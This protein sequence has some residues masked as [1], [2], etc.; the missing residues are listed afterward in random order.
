MNLYQ[1]ASQEEAW[2]A[3]APNDDLSPWTA[4]PADPPA[5]MP[6]G[7]VPLDAALDAAAREYGV[8]AD[9][10]RALGPG[11]SVDSIFDTAASLR[12]RLEAFGGDYAQAL[13]SYRQAEGG[14]GGNIA[15]APPAAALSPPPL[16]DAQMPAPGPAPAREHSARPAGAAPRPRPPRAQA[17]TPA[18]GAPPLQAARQGPKAAPQ[19]DGSSPAAPDG[20]LGAAD[21]PRS[22]LYR[23][24]PAPQTAFMDEVK[25]QLASGAKTLARMLPGTGA[26]AHW[27]ASQSEPAAGQ[28]APPSA[29]S[30]FERTALPAPDLPSRDLPLRP[31]TRKAANNAWDAASPQDRQRMQALPGWQGQ[32]ARERAAQFAQADKG[33][34]AESPTAALFDTRVEGRTRALIAK[35]E[36][37]DFARRAAR[38]GAAAGVAP[39]QEVKALGSTV[40][41]APRH[42]AK[43]PVP[44]MTPLSV[45]QD[46]LSGALQIGTTAAKGGADIVRMATGDAVG[47]DFSDSMAARAQIIKDMVGSDRAKAQEHNFQVDWADPNVSA[48]EMLARNKGAVSDKLLPSAG[49]MLLPAGVATGAGKAATLGRTALALDRTALAAR[50]A[51]AQTAAGI[52]ATAAQNAADVF[53]GLLDKGHSPEE[54]YTAAG[55]SVP[56]SIIAGKLTGGGA[57]TALARQAMRQGTDKAAK[58][59]LA[60]G[61]AGALKAG[62]RDGTQEVIEDSGQ[63]IGEAIATD[64]APTAN[65]AAKRGLLAFTMG[66]AMGGGTHAAG[67]T[68]TPRVQNQPTPP[69]VPSQQDAAANKTGPTTE[70]T[71]PAA[72]FARSAGTG[73]GTGNAA[74]A[75][76]QASAPDMAAGPTGEPAP[77]ATTWSDVAAAAKRARAEAEILRQAAALPEQNAAASTPDT[78]SRNTPSATPAM[79]TTATAAATNTDIGIGSTSH[80]W[81]RVDTPPQEQASSDADQA[82][83]STQ[84]TAPD[85]APATTQHGTARHTAAS[86]VQP[87]TTAPIDAQVQALDSGMLVVGGDQATILA[88]LQAGGIRGAEPFAGVTLVPVDQAALAQQVLSRPLAAPAGKRADR[89]SQ[90]ASATATLTWSGTEAQLAPAAT[91]APTAGGSTADP[92]AVGASA[93]RT[94][95]RHGSPTG[96]AASQPVPVMEMQRDGTLMV[97]GDSVQLEERLRAGGVDRVLRREGGVLVGLDQV[98]KARQLFSNPQ[99]TQDRSRAAPPTSAVARREVATSQSDFVAENHSNGYSDNDGRVQEPTQPDDGRGSTTGRS[100]ATA[101]DSVRGP[102]NAVPPRTASLVGV[103]IA[104]RIERAGSQSLLGEQVDSP[105]RLAELAQVYRDPRFETFR[106]F[107]IK[108]GQVVHATGVSARLPGET[109]MVPAGMTFSEYI[110]EFRDNMQRTGADGYY[111]LHNHPSGNPRPSPEDLN[112]TADLEAHVP[113]M[114]A[115]VV[116]N[117]NK[118]AVIEPTSAG[119]SPD[120]MVRFRY[121]GEDRLLKASKPMAVLGERI[122]GSDDL[123]IVGKSMQRPGWITLIGT[124][125][126]GKVRAIS[127]APA[128]ILTRNYP[129]L[130]ATVRRFMRQSGSGSVFAVGDAGDIGSKPVRDALA[131]GIL[132]DALP[133]AGRTL[134]QQGVHTGGTGFSLTRGRR[135]AEGGPAPTSSSAADMET[136]RDGTLMVRG[137]SVQL[138]ERLRQGGVERVLRREGGVLVGLDQVRKARQLLQQQP[139]RAPASADYSLPSPLSEQQFSRNAPDQNLSRARALPSKPATV[140]S[141]RAAVAKLTNSMGLL[142]EGRGRVVVATSAD[143]QAHWEPLVGEVDMASQDTGL[144]QGF[145]DPNTNTVFLIADHIEAGQEMAVAAHE[146]VHKHGKAVLG[147]ARWRQLHGVI[148]SWANRPEGSLERRVYDEA[149]ARVQASR[150]DNADAAAYSSEELFPYAVQVA[151][152]LGVQPTALMPNNSVQG[153]LARVRAALRSVFEK[154]TGQPGL[155]DSQDLVNLAWGI[156]QR[157]NPEHARELDAI[158]TEVPGDVQAVIDSARQPGHVPQKAVLGHASDWLVENLATHGL[159]IAG[160]RHVIEGSAVRHIIKNHYDEKSARYRGLLP[161]SDQDLLRLPDVIAAPD[162][163]VLGT[164]N[165]LGKQQIAYIKNMGDGSVLYLDEMRTGKKELAAVSAK[166]FP[167]TMNVEKVISTLHPNAQSDGGKSLIVL[168]PPDHH[169]LEDPPVRRGNLL[170]SRTGVP[171]VRKASTFS[172]AREA[173]RQ[174][175]GKQLTNESTG[176]KAVVS[177]NS[178]DKMLSGKA[179]AKSETPATHAMAVANADSLFSQAILGWSKQDRSGDVNIRAV[180]R[181]FAH[182][183]VSG[184]SKL[185]KLTVKETGQEGR[186][187]PLYTVEAVELNEHVPSTQWLEA[188]AHEDGLELNTKDPQRGEWVGEI[189]D[190]R[191]IDP[192]TTLYGVQ[193]P[194]RAVNHAAEDV[195]SLAQEIERRNA[196]GDAADDATPRFST[197]SNGQGPG[198]SLEQVQQLVQQA[199]SGLRNPPPVDVVLRAADL[200]IVAPEGAMGVWAGNRLAIVVENHRQAI[201]VRE[202]VFHELFHAGLSN[203][204]PRRDYVQ[205]MLDLAKRDARVHQY[206]V[207]WKKDAPEAAMQLQA[208]RDAGFTG[209]E[210]TAQYEALA[211]EEGLAVVAEELRGRMQAGLRLGEQVRV[212]AGWLASLADRMGMHSLA[213]AIRAMTYSEAERFVIRAIDHAGAAGG[214]MKN[215]GRARFSTR[216]AQ[217]P[218]VGATT[219]SAQPTDSEQ[220]RMQRDG[221]LMVQGDPVQ[222]QERL[223]QGGV[224]SVLRRERGVLVGLDQVG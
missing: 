62:L 105:Q 156:A 81:Q 57:E 202:T 166:K 108:D 119:A 69:Q 220:M 183:Q 151:M 29:G 201:Q 168:T 65:E 46:A 165:R 85:T 191:K 92:N 34:L 143:I 179:V 169:N 63:M 50:V 155:F 101:L 23:Q 30:V 121:F 131:A 129:Y 79:A 207:D 211:I 109:P 41:Q 21:D 72:E 54:A 67:A 49:S 190:P 90:R 176:L 91:Q 174:F 53:T 186:A 107:F 182:M 74:P 127:E 86:Q 112:A 37:P 47:K 162:K 93:P 196:R 26:A 118:Y 159:E 9:V 216:S 140:Q 11:S 48:M 120:S 32:L 171:R 123:A 98:G 126:D 56:F 185:V 76:G 82:G 60:S 8:N 100:R 22:G 135:V 70:G 218:Q 102:G 45:A 24:A 152:E 116:I 77:G 145:Y 137:D 175:Q 189:A 147:E 206:A 134:H 103:G 200:G 172:E 139:P 160:F 146:L 161:L 209:S 89:G 1:L 138:Q 167:A 12:S 96:A 217:P 80:P 83:T 203:I 144:V 36:H 104:E 125:A 94:E 158:W 114:L 170:F 4:W 136:Q 88:H 99:S 84:A 208:L 16:A 111:V 97:K 40:Q 150:P 222:L 142:A 15:L 130:A 18:P 33:L 215:V 224:D 39:G 164:T 195:F 20:R 192:R 223:R 148:G 51:S 221:T 214:E 31:E 173:A 212:L 187:N 42:A 59:D 197:R 25:N 154:L 141:V 55:I 198:L 210:L 35:G 6:P 117:S 43:V 122:A 61:A 128:S 188:A 205:A 180:H 181:F 27:V 66:T 14:Q 213:D 194:A 110:K 184:R 2:G 95:G 44:A 106:V 193:L 219:V 163:V 68:H 153:W 75:A 38:E 58:G 149:A 64:V 132:R 73:S 87:P 157:E 17:G 10:L 78:T 177:R 199:L 3:Y 204:L 113:G 71:A 7:P 133:D 5:P 52:G 178:L 19:A 115:H 28:A 13:A 124:G